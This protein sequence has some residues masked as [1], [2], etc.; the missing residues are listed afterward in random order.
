MS[1]MSMCSSVVRRPTSHRYIS[2]KVLLA[3]GGETPFM[4]HCC[5]YENSYRVKFLHGSVHDILFLAISQANI[6]TKRKLQ[7]IKM[8]G[9]ILCPS[10]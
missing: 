3:E 7:E 5:N 6:L 8:N 9:I 10:Y 4:E 1:D 2:T